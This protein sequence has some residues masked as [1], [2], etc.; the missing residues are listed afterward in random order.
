MTYGW[1]ILVVVIAVGALSYFGVLK[2]DTFFP[3]KCSLPAGLACLDY[4]VES[5]K[6]VI[7]LQN[8]Q[9]VINVSIEDNGIGLSPNPTRSHHYGL[10]IMQERA[11]TLGGTLSWQN[12][13]HG[14]TQIL[15]TLHESPNETA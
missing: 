13:P 3:D 4:R 1:A 7:V 12:A 9:G 6:V 10:T 11:R 2:T 5:F 14:G 8:A 15:L